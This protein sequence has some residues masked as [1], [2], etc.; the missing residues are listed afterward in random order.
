M[1]H[2]GDTTM[3]L[4]LLRPMDDTLEPWMPW[5]DRM[6]GFVIRAESE[7]KARAVASRNA[8][9]EGPKAWLLPNNSK[10]VE[11]LPDGEEE[12]V[13]EEYNPPR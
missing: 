1:M 5:H 10:C 12:V 7:S 2:P 3:K 4:W 8:G 9:D 11:L 13:L 6:F